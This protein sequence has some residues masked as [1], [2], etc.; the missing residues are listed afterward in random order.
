MNEIKTIYMVCDDWTGQAEYY[1]DPDRA[2]RRRVERFDKFWEGNFSWHNGKAD[3][4]DFYIHE[5]ELNVGG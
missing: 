2:E 1:D 3:P 5:H 4:D